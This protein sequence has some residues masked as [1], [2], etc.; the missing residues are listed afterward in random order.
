MRELADV[1]EKLHVPDYISMCQCLL[2]LDDA[3]AVAKV[4]ATLIAKEGD[5]TLMSYQ[6]AYE[7]AENENQPFL[8]RVA[9]A[10]PHPKEKKV[11]V[12]DSSRTLLLISQYRMTLRTIPLIRLNTGCQTFALFSQASR[13][14]R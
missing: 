10:L 2:Y 13:Q 6:V 7:L 9:N 11:G 5:D 14:S 12:M 4:L 3:A 1:Y 8:L